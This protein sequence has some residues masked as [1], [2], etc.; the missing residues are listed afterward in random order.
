M[1]SRNSIKI[2]NSHYT[3]R[4][5]PAHAL[6]Q[7]RNRHDASDSLKTTPLSQQPESMMN[8]CFI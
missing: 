7:H 1:L 4:L 2:L 8:Y 3:K 6:L 5:F